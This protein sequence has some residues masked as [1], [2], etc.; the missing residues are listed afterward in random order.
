MRRLCSPE[1]MHELIPG[2]MVEDLFQM[3]AWSKD[4]MM[5]IQQWFDLRQ[6]MAEQIEDFGWQH[7]LKAANDLGLDPEQAR[8]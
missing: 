3:K 7:R 5:S 4:R 2:R 1:A 8:A 6:V